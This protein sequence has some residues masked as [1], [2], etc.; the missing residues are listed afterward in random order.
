MAARRQ[1]SREFKLEAVKR[2]SQ[3][4]DGAGSAEKSR[5]LLREEVDLK[6]GFIAKH[7]GLAGQFD[8]QG[9]RCLEGPFLYLAEASAEP[10]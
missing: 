9:T 8:V 1:F 6:F 7:R 10:A 3:A 4:Q 2:G 5:G